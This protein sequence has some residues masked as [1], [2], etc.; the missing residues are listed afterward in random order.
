LAYFCFFKGPPRLLIKGLKS[1][2]VYILESFQKTNS[3][4]LLFLGQ[5]SRLQLQALQNTTNILRE[6]WHVVRKAHSPTH[7]FPLYYET[8]ADLLWPLKAF[9]LNSL[10]SNRAPNL[11]KCPLGK[12]QCIRGSSYMEFIVLSP[13]GHPHLFHRDFCLD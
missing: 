11:R 9:F 5:S 10:V 2:H 4:F 6:F 1:I 7:L 13:H 8:V 3:V 12:K